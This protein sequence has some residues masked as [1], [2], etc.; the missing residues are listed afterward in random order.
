MAKP[1]TAGKKSLRPAVSPLTRTGQP[2]KGNKGVPSK[3][4]PELQV[5][6]VKLMGEGNYAE[7]VCDAVMLSQRT[8]TEWM[9]R[10]EEEERGGYPEGPYAQFT[11]AIK[12]AAAE[13][14]IDALRQIKQ[15]KFNWQALAWFGERRYPNLYGQRQRFEHSGP[16][17][18]P[19]Q[20]Q[21]NLSKL[22]KEELKVMR[23]LIA[24]AGEKE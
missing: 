5:R 6:M 16:Q 3:L 11:L 21:V 8:F 9:R 10:G 15:R 13:A 18:G 22:S 14:L 4:T 17:G 23:K 2:R 7:T 24:K 12:K 19:I 20:T 1:K